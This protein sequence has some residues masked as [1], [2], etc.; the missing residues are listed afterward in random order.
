MSVG[1]CAGLAVLLIVALGP[2]SRGLG[3][4]VDRIDP[5]SW[6]VDRQD[7]RVNLLIEGSGLRGA[8]VRV[9]RG[10]IR[11]ERVDPGDDGRA[12]FVEVTIPGGIATGALHTRGSGRGPDD[13][14]R[15]GDRRAASP[16]ARAVR[17]RRRDL[18]GHARP[19]LRRRSGQ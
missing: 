9:T 1:K 8:E 3:Q 12:L 18:P 17:A 14:A 19:L 4:A 5:P 2:A 16:P 7:Q 11:V 6:W 13:P 10:S 15:L